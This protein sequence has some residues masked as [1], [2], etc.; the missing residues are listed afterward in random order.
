MF[1]S[2]VVIPT[3][4]TTRLTIRAFEASD[5]DALVARRNDPDVA[6]YQ[7]WELPYTRERAEERYGQT[8]DDGDDGWWIGTIVLTET[9][10]IVGDMVVEYTWNGRSAEIGY[11]LDREHW[12]KGYAV[13]AA[14]AL[15]AHLWS[16]PKITR[17]S[18][19]LHP[20]NPASAMVLEKVGMLFEGHTR[21]SFW[22]GDENSDDW[23]YGMTRTDW[24]DWRSRPRHR[25]ETV[26]LVEVT[27]ENAWDI[28]KL[29]THKTQE[30]FVAPMAYSYA[31]ALFPGDH[32]GVPVVP[33]MRGV[34]ADGEW[35]GF[36]MVAEGIETHPDPYLWRMLI[37]RRH[38]RR[39]IGHRAMSLLYEHFRELG[40]E[41]L[42]VS[43][44]P[45]RG[46]P[47]PFYLS[48]GFEPTGEIDEGEIVARKRL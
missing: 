10:D 33:W 22:V 7:T 34:R 41:W 39:G 17:V 18:G 13:E 27:E 26:E 20:D 15:V 28:Y 42:Y 47:E 44:A 45:G 6:R 23:T 38:Q 2:T 12:G 29:K 4:P 1:E 24:E 3:L 43:W 11:S 40:H 9:G 25:P 35:A 19:M 46:G 37:D 16:D 48:H 31:D 14:E 21:N 5:I 32:E 30:R 36:L 8:T